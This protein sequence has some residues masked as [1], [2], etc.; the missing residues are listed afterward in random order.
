[1]VYFVFFGVM[2]FLVLLG[3]LF[4]WVVVE[5][6]WMW[7]VIDVLVKVVEVDFVV[8]GVGLVGCSLIGW[9]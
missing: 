9:F 1:M 4:F 6:Y 5:C 8:I 3:G 7:F 2:I